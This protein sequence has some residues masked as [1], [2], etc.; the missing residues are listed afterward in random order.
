MLIEHLD[1]T[2]TTERRRELT[3]KHGIPES[4]AEDALVA[5]LGLPQKLKFRDIFIQS[6]LIPKRLIPF[7]KKPQNR[8]KTDICLLLDQ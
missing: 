1:Q 3:S 7:V 6:V 5:L 8:I 4:Q 2:I